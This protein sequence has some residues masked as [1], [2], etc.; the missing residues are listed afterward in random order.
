MVFEVSRDL[1]QTA[2]NIEKKS[3]FLGNIRRGN[4]V[5]E[6]QVE[7]ITK[8]VVGN[9]EKEFGKGNIVWHG[10]CT[11]HAFVKTRV[12]RLLDKSR[13]E[14]LLDVTIN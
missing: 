10:D 8:L 1:I 9:A 3:T 2:L 4:Y 14:P 13:E 5:R 11:L 12:R 7:K 6:P